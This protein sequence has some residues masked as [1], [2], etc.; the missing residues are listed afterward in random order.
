MA[1]AKEKLTSIKSYHT[2]MRKINSLFHSM[3]LTS[4]TAKQRDATLR[5]TENNQ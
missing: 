4:I 5:E 1:D 3:G 2:L